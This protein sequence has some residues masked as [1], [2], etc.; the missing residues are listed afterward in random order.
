M[1]YFSQIVS[2][3]RR[4]AELENSAPISPAQSVSLPA[5][6]P[7]S[8]HEEAP[9]GP[10]A[11]GQGRGAPVP[12]EAATID[13]S[14]TPQ[15]ESEDERRKAHE[16][17]EAERRAEWEAR[18]LAKRA[19]ENEAIQKVAS[20]SDE[21]AAAEAAKRVAADTERITRRNMKEMV[22]EHIQRICASDPD[23][24]RLVMH[25]RKSMVRCF[26]YI[27]RKALEYA[28]QEMKNN[29][30]EHRGV[31]GLDV[32]DG[33]CYQWAVDYFNDP[34]APEDHENDEKF[35]PKPYVPKN[36]S[37]KPK[38][39]SKPKTKPKAQPEKPTKQ[40]EGSTQQ[41]SI[42]EVG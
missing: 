4:S 22:C 2:D 20:M 30:I 3:A 40:P 11:R 36:G 33:L 15:Q 12:S 16:A 23:F 9:S 1:G 35:T 8:A 17:S 6:A 26:A 13:L 7:A 21:Q 39:K 31:Y 19:A 25:P 18:Q 10:V 14:T 37:S 5:E 32:P 41:M 29:G 38:A 42:L 28:E 24:A 34:D 27:N